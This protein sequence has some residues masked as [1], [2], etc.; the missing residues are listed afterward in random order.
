MRGEILSVERRRRWNDDDK[1]AIVSSVGIDGATVTH[2]AHRHDVTRQQ[3]YR[4]RHE[5]K[6][7]GLW[8]T[9]DGAVFVPIDFHVAEMAAPEPAPPSPLELRL[10]NG[11]CLRFD[12]GVDTAALTRLIRAVDAA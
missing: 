1:L 8:P 10:S 4:W 12:T 7:K 5:L 9:G 3:I 2:V 11:R 6:K